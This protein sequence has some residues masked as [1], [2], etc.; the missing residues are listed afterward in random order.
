MDFLASQGPRPV[1]QAACR[2]PATAPTGRYSGAIEESAS[3]WA[4]AAGRV[5]ALPTTV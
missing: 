3:D 2:A 4:R 5:M 1:L